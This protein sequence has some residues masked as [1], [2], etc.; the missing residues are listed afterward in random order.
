MQLSCVNVCILCTKGKAASAGDLGFLLSERHRDKMHAWHHVFRQS[1][2]VS[3]IHPESGNIFL[4]TGRYFLRCL[5]E[6]IDVR[7]LKALV[8]F[9]LSEIPFCFS[10]SKNCIDL[11]TLSLCRHMPLCRDFL[12][13]ASHS[14]NSDPNP[15]RQI[16]CTLQCFL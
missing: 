13:S 12:T 11:K 2:Y 10:N 14:S 8:L 4:E 7:K 5:I 9:P 3:Q 16:P 1:F 15:S 6:K